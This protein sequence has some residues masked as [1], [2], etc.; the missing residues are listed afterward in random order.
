VR[1]TP[2]IKHTIPPIIFIN[3]LSLLFAQLFKA[4]VLGRNQRKKSI[5]K[6]PKKILIRPYEIKKNEIKENFILNFLIY[7]CSLFIWI[8][9][10]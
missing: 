3:L 8:P 7:F 4:K 2:K 5:L 6:T 1:I 9:S 10:E